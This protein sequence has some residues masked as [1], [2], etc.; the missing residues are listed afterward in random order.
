LRSSEIGEVAELVQWLPAGQTVS[1]EPG[2]QLQARMG[3]ELADVL[4]Y[5]VRLAD[6]I[7]VDLYVEA[8]NKIQRNDSR[9]PPE[10]VRGVAPER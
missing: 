1:V 8:S 7:G 3:D 4:L 5:L 9:F 2:G 10:R 6:V